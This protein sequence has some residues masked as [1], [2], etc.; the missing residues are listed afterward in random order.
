MH[1][2]NVKFNKKTSPRLVQLGRASLAGGRQARMGPTSHGACEEARGGTQASTEAEE[3]GHVHVNLLKKKNRAKGSGPEEHRRL[4]AKVHAQ[5]RDS[6]SRGRQE[7]NP[8][9]RW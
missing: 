5:D 7:G 4:I 6:T 9:G 1:A 3:A 8:A 2:R